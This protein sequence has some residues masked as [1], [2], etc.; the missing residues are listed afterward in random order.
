MCSILSPTPL[1]VYLQEGG[2]AETGEEPHPLQCNLEKGGAD[3][4]VL[5]QADIE[6]AVTSLTETVALCNT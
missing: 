5:F 6:R 2:G 4:V 3:F 1:Q